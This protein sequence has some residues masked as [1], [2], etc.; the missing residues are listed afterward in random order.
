MLD[1]Q[2]KRQKDKY[3]IL[4]GFINEEIIPESLEDAM[5]LSVK[6]LHH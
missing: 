1:A 4:L 5:F 2:I 3:E 6:S